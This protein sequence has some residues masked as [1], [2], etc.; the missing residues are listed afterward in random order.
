MSEL[1]SSPN[2]FDPFIDRTTLANKI[3]IFKSLN[4]ADVLA[5][6]EIT[7]GYSPAVFEKLLGP[8]AAGWF[9]GLA[10]PKLSELAEL[11]ARLGIDLFTF[12]GQSGYFNRTTTP[13]SAPTVATDENQTPTP[14]D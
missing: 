5:T 6:L 1:A 12:T 2:P 11:E 4:L 10:D 8:I 13:P 14:V 7:G 3:C 9:S